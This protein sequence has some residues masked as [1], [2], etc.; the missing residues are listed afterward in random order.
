M[1]EKIL[2]AIIIIIATI[3]GIGVCI[4]SVHKDYIWGRKSFDS[5]DESSQY[6]S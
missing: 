4:L 1:L 2:T 5:K 6:K 3:S